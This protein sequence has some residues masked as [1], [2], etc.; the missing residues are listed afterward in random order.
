MM[1]DSVTPFHLQVPLFQG[2]A[3]AE[4]ESL[5]VVLTEKVYR[6]KS[7]VYYQGSEVEDLF[8]I[9][10]GHVKV[11][12]IFL[13]IVSCWAH[14]LPVRALTLSESPSLL[15]PSSV[16]APADSSLHF[17]FAQFGCTPLLINTSCSQLCMFNSNVKMQDQCPF[18]VV[19]TTAHV[20]CH[21]SA[22]ATVQCLSVTQTCKADVGVVLHSL[23]KCEMTEL[24]HAEQLCKS[25]IQ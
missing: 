3:P 22:A 12:I 19:Q 8:F 11:L 18:Q 4:I 24:L 15:P 13:V 16:Q 21:M 25:T 9:Q 2:M 14:P 1:Y 20:T 6:P 7:V 17:L 5:A 10:R 23:N